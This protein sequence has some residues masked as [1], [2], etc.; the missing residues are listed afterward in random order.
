MPA[1]WA[2]NLSSV[3]CINVS[4]PEYSQSFLFSSVTQC[5][6]ILPRNCFM[7]ETAATNMPQRPVTDSCDVPALTTKDL[8][9]HFWLCSETRL[10]DSLSFNCHSFTD[11]H[12]LMW[13][14]S[15]QQSGPVF[16]SDVLKKERRSACSVRGVL[17]LMWA[18]L[19]FKV[20]QSKENCTSR[21]HNNLIAERSPSAELL[22][23]G[24][25]Q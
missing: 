14:I 2:F 9:S 18:A 1:D 4:T 25:L 16:C 8:D 15:V 19:L 21:R 24:H 13:L 6:F 11:H 7:V 22:V 3:V 20:L 10:M 12:Y 17:K 23:S 5:A